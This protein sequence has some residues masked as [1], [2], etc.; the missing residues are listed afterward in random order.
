LRIFLTKKFDLIW[1]NDGLSKELLWIPPRVHGSAAGAELQTVRDEAMSWIETNYGDG[2][3][4]YTPPLELQRGYLFF[5]IP[6][7]SDH[8]FI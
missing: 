1:T 7:S 6:R 4:V 2:Y 3:Q 5:S 8:N